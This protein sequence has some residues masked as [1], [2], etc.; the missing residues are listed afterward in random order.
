VDASTELEA[1]PAAYHFAI[2]SRQAD[3]MTRIPV[4]IHACEPK[5]DIC[6]RTSRS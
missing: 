1:F 2:A 4:R 5:P 3:I 6:A